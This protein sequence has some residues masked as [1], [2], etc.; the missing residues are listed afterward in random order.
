VTRALGAALALALLVLGAPS[1]VRAQDGPRPTLAGHTFVSTDLVPDAFVRTYA[2][3][4]LGAAI[5]QSVDYPPIVVGADTLKVLNGSLNY[6]TLGLE[7]QGLLRDWIAARISLGLVTRLGTQGASLVREGITLVQ[8]YDF[9]FLIRLRQ[10][11]KTSLCGTVGAANQWVTQVDVEQYRQDVANGV[12]N[13]KLV[14]YVPAVRTNAGLRYAWAASPSFGVTAL[15][16]TT[17]GDAPQRHDL[18]SWGWD[19]GVSL[20]YDLAPSHHIPFGAALA[21]R[22]TS[23]PGLT[24]TSNGNS[25]QTVLR[26]AYAGRNDVIALDFLGLF[27]RQNSLAEAIWASGVAFSMRTYF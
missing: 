18:T 1:P 14:D 25:S 10:T 2:R 9:G 11:D 6:A 4:S 21:S 23:A 5:S 12:P 19:L 8:G 26:L 20:D 15:G 24:N 27:D 13:A 7:Y 16:Q 3:T 22:L 17:Y